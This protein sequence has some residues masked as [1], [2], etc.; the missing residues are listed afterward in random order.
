MLYATTVKKSL[1]FDGGVQVFYRN[2]TTQRWFIINDERCPNG[3]YNSYG[4]QCI[5]YL[6]SCDKE[7][8][9]VVHIHTNVTHKDGTPKPEFM[10]LKE[11]GETVRVLYNSQ[12]YV[13]RP[14][15]TSRSNCIVA[16]TTMT[17]DLHVVLKDDSVFKYSDDKWTE[18]SSIVFR[19]S[20]P[21]P[22]S[23]LPLPY[24]TMYSFRDAGY[25]CFVA[26][27]IACGV[28]RTQ[29]IKYTYDRA[30]ETYNYTGFITIES[31]IV[32]SA[33][34]YFLT[35]NKELVCG[36]TGI[37]MANDVALPY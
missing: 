14:P 37:I 35:S 9:K 33:G 23:S 2:N 11:N 32:D 8:S 20:P 1:L 34:G 10:I 28:P 19:K 12:T 22:H 31:L 7:R 29:I 25:E 27:P 4:S 36:E 17:E 26:L 6:N 24:G 18:V 16:Y 13:T 21:W 15:L 3:G 30:N 5:S